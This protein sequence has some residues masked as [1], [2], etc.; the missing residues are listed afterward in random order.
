MPGGATWGRGILVTGSL[1]LA[2]A[3]GYFVFTAEVRDA[4]HLPIG[5]LILFFA[6]L[7]SLLWARAGRG[8]LPV[9]EVLMLTTANTYA[10]PLLNGHQELIFYAP[11]DI[12]TAGLAVLTFQITAIATYQLIGGRPS[13]HPFWREEVITGELGNWLMYGMGLNTAYLLISTFSD[14]IPGEF[15][16]I[17]RAIFFGIGIVSTFIG[18][19]HWGA[20]RLSRGEQIYF[21]IN[22]VLQCIAM[23]TTLLLVGAVSLLLLALIGYVSSSGRIPFLVCALSLVGLAVLHHGKPQ[24]REKYWEGDRWRPT[25]GELPAYFSEWIEYGTNFESDDDSG[26]KVTSKLIE[27]TSLF[28]IMCLVVSASPT[29][30]PYLEGETYKDI[31]GQFVP[32]LL[33]PEKPPGHVSTSRLAVYYGLQTEEDT[34]KTTI[35]FGM[36]AEGYANFGFIGVGAVGALLAFFFK[37]LQTWGQNAP[38][39]SY[40][41]LILVLVL[42]WSFQ[43][44]FTLSIWLASLYQACVAVLILPFTLRRIF[45]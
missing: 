15:Q 32:R 31:P 21:A 5:L 41:G 17:L 12:T 29:L 1:G 38:L 30:Q 26:R 36:V 16:S 35:G 44:E 13:S 8:N 6:G 37:K 22:L 24:M 25:P 33:W 27:R 9:F 19:R 7:P 3:I 39:F 28:H 23:I 2:A 34:A 40:G 11:E 14:L 10:F 45:G 42:A 43:V 4:A 18:S 20:G